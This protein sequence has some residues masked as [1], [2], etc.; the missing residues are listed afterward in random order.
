MF[1][2]PHASAQLVKLAQTKAFGVLD[3]DERGIGNVNSYLY[4]CRCDKNVRQSCGKISHYCIFFLRL[5][6]A[7][8][9]GN[10]QIGKSTR[11]LLRVLG[12]GFELYGQLLI[13][14]HHRT[15]DKYLPPLAGQL[16][17]KPVEPL[18]VALIHGKGIDLLPAGRKLV[19]HRHVKVPVYHQG[20]RARDRRCGHYK[21]MRLC[22]LCDKRGALTHTETVLLIRHNKGK[23]GI[24]RIT[25][26]KRVRTHD[27]SAPAAA[28]Q[29][30]GGALLLCGHRA[31]K[32]H[33]AYAHRREQLSKII[34][35]LLGKD[36][37]G[38][39][40]GA[41]VPA[42]ADG[43]YKRR[44]NERF[45]AADVALHKPVHHVA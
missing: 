44:R 28:H 1:S 20:K 30:L 13:F 26:K 34:I 22:A 21:H 6:P 9:A 17:Y 36:L 41:H 7:V 39:H 4:D 12:R 18:T 29:F 32:L 27:K 5:H 24:L 31:G 25:G 16:S 2:A 23:I 40:E 38:R 15:D 35:M 11:K 45:P 10:V 14:V 43:V 3:Y 37:G 33:D 42:A 8:D 19:D